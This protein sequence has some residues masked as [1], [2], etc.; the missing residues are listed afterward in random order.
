MAAIFAVLALG[1]LARSLQF[2]SLNTLSF[3]DLP[4]DRL[5]AGTAISGTVQQLSVALGVVLASATLE[6]GRVMAG[7]EAP[8]LADFQLGFLV[9]GA[10]ALLA[11]PSALRLPREAGA[12][13]SGHGKGG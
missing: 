9:A 10:L 12:R 13:I 5:A 4:P 7:R 2:T 3:A 1:G 8:A 11:I 6:A